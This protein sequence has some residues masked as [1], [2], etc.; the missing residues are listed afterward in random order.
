MS[1]S[2]RAVT[3]EWSKEL[4][5]PSDQTRWRPA[6][7]S[8]QGL[9]LA[10]T[11][12]LFATYSRTAFPRPSGPG[13][14]SVAGWGSTRAVARWAGFSSWTAESAL[15]AANRSGRTSN[16]GHDK[17]ARFTPPGRCPKALGDL[18]SPC[19]ATTRPLRRTFLEIYAAK[20]RQTTRQRAGASAAGPVFLAESGSGKPLRRR[21]RGGATFVSQP[22]RRGSAGK[23]DT[24]IPFPPVFWL[25]ERSS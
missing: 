11:R 4:C 24:V 21:R 7:P 25:P 16:N 8:P 3:R 6:T 17:P 13:S 10:L 2:L 9:S 15:A 18:R 23:A 14:G 1:E 12:S 20:R 5:V 22:A 19:P